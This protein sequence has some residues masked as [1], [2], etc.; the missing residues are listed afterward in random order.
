M[1][2][3]NLPVYE[4]VSTAFCFCCAESSVYGITLRKVCATEFKDLKKKKPKMC[5]FTVCGLT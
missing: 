3:T 5:E 4:D 1:V 2:L